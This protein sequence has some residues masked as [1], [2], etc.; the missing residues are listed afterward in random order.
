[1]SHRELYIIEKQ[2]DIEI[3]G[4]YTITHKLLE[5]DGEGGREGK[6]EGETQQLTSR[7][8]GVERTSE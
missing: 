1:L 2:R 7:V 5:R 6:R 3:E 8:K 4:M